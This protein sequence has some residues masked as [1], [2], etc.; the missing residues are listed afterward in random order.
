MNPPLET[1][2]LSQIQIEDDRTGLSIETLKRAILDK[3][4]YVQGKYPEIATKNDL[5]MALA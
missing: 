1:T 3:L 4:L 2:S 5:Y